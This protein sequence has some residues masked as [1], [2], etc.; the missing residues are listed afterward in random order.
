[1]DA[2]FSTQYTLLSNVQLERALDQR[3][4]GLASATSTRIGRNMPVLVDTNLI[5]TGLT[6]ADGRPIF[7]TAVDARPRA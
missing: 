2:D 5:P 7:S 3:P 4:L 1:M 6:L